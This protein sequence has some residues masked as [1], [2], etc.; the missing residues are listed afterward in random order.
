[1]GASKA[2]TGGVGGG[3]GLGER[4]IGVFASWGAGR[5][6]QT[7]PL[8]EASVEDDDEAIFLA[9]RG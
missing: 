4:D 3:M 9:E 5:V 6:S 2:V 7:Y 1:M 8:D